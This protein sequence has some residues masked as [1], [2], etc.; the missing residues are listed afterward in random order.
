VKPIQVGD[1]VPIR[2]AL[3]SAYKELGLEVP[4]DGYPTEHWNLAV[5]VFQTAMSKQVSCLH[6][7]GHQNIYQVF[8]CFDCKGHLCENCAPEHFGPR[9][10]ERAAA[11]HPA[12]R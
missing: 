6:C 3:E 10:A 2:N 5:L 9:H 11:S 8:R 12:P 7:G 1:W 4:K